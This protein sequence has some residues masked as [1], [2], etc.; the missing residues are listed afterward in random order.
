MVTSHQQRLMRTYRNAGI[1][2]VRIAEIFGVC[3]DTVSYHTSDASN[4]KLKEKARIKS[5][6]QYW[7][8]KGRRPIQIQQDSTNA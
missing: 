2:M 3:I 6:K 5:K 4:K 7:A 8:K 1:T